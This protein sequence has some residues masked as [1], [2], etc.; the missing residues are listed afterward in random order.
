MEQQQPP[1]HGI[2]SY[3]H[4]SD[5]SV[6][7]SIMESQ[8]ETHRMFLS[9]MDEKRR[10]EKLA[11]EVRQIRQQL[12]NANTAT[13]STARTTSTTKPASQNTV[14]VRVTHTATNG[15]KWDQMIFY[16]SSHGVNPTHSNEQCTNKKNC[17]VDGATLHDRKGGSTTNLDKLMW[18]CKRKTNKDPVREYRESAPE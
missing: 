5:P 6:G 7:K 17:H 2:P 3:V 15:A 10:A 4:T 9:Y 13:C 18:W 12:T 8:A 11:E 1:P 16:C 14:D